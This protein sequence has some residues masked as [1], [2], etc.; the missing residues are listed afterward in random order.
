M[1][2]HLSCARPVHLTQSHRIA[3]SVCVSI[4]VQGHLTTGTYRQEACQVPCYTWGSLKEGGL[5][6]AQ[7]A[8]ASWRSGY[9]S[10]VFKDG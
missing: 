10:G 7:A 8:E 3:A 4:G 6:G 5:P 2:V 9:P 1:Q